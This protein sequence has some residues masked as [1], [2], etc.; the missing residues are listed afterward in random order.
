MNRQE[1]KDILDS[2]TI[3]EGCDKKQMLQDLRPLNVAILQLIPERL[4]KYRACCPNHINAFKKDEVWM[5]TS[6]LFNDPFD[7]LIQC[8]SQEI[9]NVFNLIDNPQLLQG[10]AM[11]VAD[12]GSIPEPLNGMLSDED[13]RA[14]QNM[15]EHFLTNKNYKN[16]D[17]ESLQQLKLQTTIVL[18]ILPT[19]IQHVSTSVCFSEDINSVL[20]WSHYSEYHQGFALG[21]DLRSFLLPNKE[22]LGLFPVVYS[23]QR[24]NATQYLCYWVGK[25]MKLPLKN[26][27]TLAQIKLLLYKSKEW[28][29]EKEWRLINSQNKDVFNKSAEPRIIRPNSI[30]YGCHI[31]E[32]NRKQLHEIAT[33][34]N[35]LEYQMR[36]DD[37]SMIYEVKAD[38]IKNTDN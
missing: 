34:K 22:N 6:D 12:G 38:E 35:L 37:S 21:Y 19:I 11:Y 26:Q 31:S 14:T 18:S 15:A 17:T 5:S 29:Y 36:I 8:D 3:P 2:I 7:T 24:Y 23:E 1:F 4:Y 28:E 25:L 30:Y 32:E 9:L 16:L 27:D 33:E 13:K 20:M 10:M